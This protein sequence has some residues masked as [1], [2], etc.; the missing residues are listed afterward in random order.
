MSIMVIGM[1]IFLCISTLMAINTQG[2]GRTGQGE[3]SQDEREKETD[4]DTDRRGERIYR[5]R[6]EGKKQCHQQ[7]HSNPLAIFLPRLI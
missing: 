2:L 3:A 4:R 7:C 6:D 1:S 5:E